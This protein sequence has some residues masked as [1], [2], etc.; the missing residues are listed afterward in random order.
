MLISIGGGLLGIVIGFGL[1]WL[2]AYSAGWKTI[3]TTGSVIVAFGVAAV[4][5]VLF[6]IYPAMNASRIDPTVA[7]RYE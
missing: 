3:V 7:L 4:T 6:G 5:G 2:I 1:S